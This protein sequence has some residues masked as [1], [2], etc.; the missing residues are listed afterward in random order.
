M[1]LM[2]YLGARKPLP[3][4]QN[5]WLK[6]ERLSEAAE[7]VRQHI[8]T[9]YVYFVA[10]HSGCSCGFPHVLAEKEIEYFDGVFADEGPERENDLASVRELMAVIDEALDGQPDCVLLPVW[11]GSEQTAPKGD[12]RW[13]RKAMSPE[14]FLLTE[15]FRYTMCVELNAALN[16]ELSNSTEQ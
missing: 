14:R 7:V 3:L 16:S 12:V 4:R 9:E 8:R 15:Q 6:L 11:C 1:C 2:L 5:A 10:S 13:D